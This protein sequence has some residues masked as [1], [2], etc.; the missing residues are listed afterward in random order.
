MDMTTRKTMLNI[1]ER[2]SPALTHG[3]AGGEVDGVGDE[4]AAAA[5]DGADDE[6]G[7]VDAR[8]FV[9]DEVDAVGDQPRAQHGQAALCDRFHRSFVVQPRGEAG[10]RVVDNPP[11]RRP[12]EPDGLRREQRDGR[13][14]RVLDQQPRQDAAPERGQ[15]RDLQ[16]CK[17]I[18]VPSLIDAA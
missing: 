9:H 5:G 13:L 16:K 17:T 14:C 2:V 6:R 10:G 7:R 18:Q 3:H 15:E 1:C 12:D 8:E 4:L 11:G